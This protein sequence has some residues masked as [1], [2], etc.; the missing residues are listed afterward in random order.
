MHAHALCHVQHRLYWQLLHLRHEPAAW[1]VKWCAD[2]H[3]LLL[4]VMCSW[5]AAAFVPL[6]TKT[7]N[8]RRAAIAS[9]IGMLLLVIAGIIIGATSS[10]WRN[11]GGGTTYYYYG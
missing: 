8:D 2:M 11:T 3:L 1:T 9:T 4:Y 10:R 7:V 6:C 5:V